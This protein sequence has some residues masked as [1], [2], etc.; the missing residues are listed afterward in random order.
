LPA[1]EVGIPDGL[2]PGDL[3]FHGH[4]HRNSRDFFRLRPDQFPRLR[5]GVGERRG[6][7]NLRP[8]RAGENQRRG[9]R[10]N[11]SGQNEQVHACPTLSA[12]R[13]L[14]T[15]K[16]EM[17]SARLDARTKGIIAAMVGAVALNRPSELIPEVFFTTDF[18]DRHG[19][20]LHIA[21][22]PDPAHDL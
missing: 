3:P 9:E 8:G 16:C 1:L 17:I 5:N 22:R 21:A 14:A 10:R 15:E 19:I 13:L 6:F 11:P 18:T 7:D 4:R 20:M 2:G 12:W